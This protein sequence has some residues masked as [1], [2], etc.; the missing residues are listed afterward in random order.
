MKPVRAYGLVSGGLDS[1]LAALVLRSQG[2]EVTAL[3]FVTPFFGPENAIRMC[4]QAGIPL[5]EIDITE[6][7]LIMLKNP[8]HGYGGNMNPCIDCHALMLKTAGEMMTADG[9]D[10]LFTGEV[11]GQRPMSQTRGS[12]IVVARTSEFE[13]YVLR[14]LS[15]GLLKETIPELK[16]LVDR[17]RL[18]SLS[19]RSRKPQIK[20]A[21]E[22]GLIDYPNPAGGCLLTDPIFSRRIK[23]LFNHSP[24][25]PVRD[26]ELLKLG[27]HFR[28]PGGGK[29]IVG[30]DKANNERISA[31]VR[32]GDAIF[33]TIGCPGPVV[34]L[35]H[36]GSEEDERLAATLCFSY[37]DAAEGE[38]GRIKIS[39]DSS[40]REL[41]VVKVAKDELKGYMI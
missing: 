30:R 19:G 3:T 5:K 4:A 13:G 26:I 16:G 22:F 33:Q 15:A 34:L 1:I 14:P 28:L 9:F 27:R 37:G 40:T 17:G 29:A 20:L 36:G 35:T 32:P 25:P 39:G 10:F 18:L 21:A 24:H 23:E 41:T 31:L 38:P 6:S 7:H 11:L 8:A 12:L 2:I